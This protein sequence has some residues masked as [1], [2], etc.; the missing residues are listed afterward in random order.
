MDASFLRTLKNFRDYDENFTAPLHGFRDAKEYY[1]V[2]SSRQYLRHIQVPTLI[3]HAKDDPF[4]TSD[5]IP[6]MEELS[7]SVHLEVTENG[8]HVGFVS[9]VVP[10]RPIYWL[11]E[12]APQ[13]FREHLG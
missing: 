1:A 10:W 5:V 12:R 2:T 9:G 13:F 11:E 3:L 7:P 6:T 4:M 8:G